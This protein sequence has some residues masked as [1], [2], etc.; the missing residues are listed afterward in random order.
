M[1]RSPLPMNTAQPFSS[2]VA[3]TS[4]VKAL[5]ARKGSRTA[6]ERTSPKVI[7]A[8]MQRRICFSSITR[9]GNG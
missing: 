4:T 6:Y 8:T 3:F 2:D 9:I 1:S 5:Q 7:S